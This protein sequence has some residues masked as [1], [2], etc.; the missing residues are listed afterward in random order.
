MGCGG[1]GWGGGRC[2]TLSHLGLLE[3]GLKSRT[4][5]LSIFTPQNF[6]KAHLLL[7]SG[8]HRQGS[9]S[10]QKARACQKG[11]VLASDPS[12]NFSHSCVVGAFAPRC[13]SICLSATPTS[14]TPVL[15]PPVSASLASRPQATFLVLCNS[16]DVESQGRASVP[17]CLGV[18]MPGKKANS[19]TFHYPHGP[20][21]SFWASAPPAG[22]LGHGVQSAQPR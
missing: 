22:L 18:E 14:F 12:G 10:P 7:R 6:A 8:F 3:S 5:N 11:T 13:P 19:R 21:F 2:L 16:Q 20:V 15:E 1:R 17:S 4:L 9:Q